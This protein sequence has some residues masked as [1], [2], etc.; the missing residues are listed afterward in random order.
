MSRNLNKFKTAVALGYREGQ[1]TAPSLSAKG[2]NLNA[3]QIVKIARRFGIPVVEKPEL[4]G[5]LKDMKI[6]QE[7]PPS[8]YEAVALVLSQLKKSVFP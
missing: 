1:Q 3:D 5:S 6:D 2:E 7:I 4:A 8:L